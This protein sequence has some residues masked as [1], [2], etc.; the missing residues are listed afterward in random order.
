MDA[1]SFAPILAHAPYT[2]NA[3]AADPSLRQTCSAWIIS[4]E[5]C[6]ISIPEAM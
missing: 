1:H 6:I 2:L 5:Q 4:R 3:C